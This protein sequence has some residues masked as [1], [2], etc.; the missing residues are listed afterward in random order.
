MGPLERLIH[1]LPP[2]LKKQV[3]DFAHSLLK[4][5]GRSSNGK[6]TLK[7]RGGLGDLRDERTSVDLQYEAGRC[8][9]D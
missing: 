9:G 2:D 7:W 6:M 1:E 3:E 4:K 5:S 8:W